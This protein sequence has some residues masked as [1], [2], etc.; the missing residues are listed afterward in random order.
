MRNVCNLVGKP[1]GKKPLMGLRR[2]LKGRPD[3]ETD[4]KEMVLP[5]FRCQ[6]YIQRNFVVCAVR[7]V[8]FGL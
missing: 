2:K 3:I 8:L 6:A 1:E 7:A 4:L 5:R